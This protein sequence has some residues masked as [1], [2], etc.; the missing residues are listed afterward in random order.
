MLTEKEREALLILVKD[1]TSFYNAN[2]LGKKLGISHVGAQKMLQRFM[3]EGLTVTKTVGK[4]RIHKPRI[5]DEYKQKLVSFLLADEANNFKRWKDEFKELFKKGR[6]V[7]IY[8]SAIKN[9]KT[10]QDIDIMVVIKKAD[11]DEVSKTINKKNKMLPKEIHCIKLTEK[12]LLDGMKEKNEAIA[13]IIKNAIILYGYD[14]YV[15]V[16]KNVAGF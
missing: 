6:I 2:S 5:D 10:A 3:E 12:D 14:T 1:F 8:G 11:A 15:E 4:S 7:L 16:V 9:Y 13:D